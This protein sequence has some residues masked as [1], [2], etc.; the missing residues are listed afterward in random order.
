MNAP[1]GPSDTDRATHAEA[2]RATHAEADRA[3]HTGDDP[4]APATVFELLGH[5]ARVEVF[6]ALCEAERS[7]GTDRPDGAHRLA[8]SALRARA[9]VDDSGRFAYHLERLTGVLLDRTDDGYALTATG[10]TLCR[11]LDASSVSVGAADG[12]APVGEC[13][14]CA[15]CSG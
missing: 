1:D 6:E 9:S 8:F 10:R 5:E 2:D 11:A 7:A 15:R 12:R 3:T 14:R 4:P 13:D